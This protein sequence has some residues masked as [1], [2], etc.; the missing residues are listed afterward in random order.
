MAEYIPV[1]LLSTWPYHGTRTRTRARKVSIVGGTSQGLI[2]ILQ[3][4][5]SWSNYSSLSL[6]W[7]RAYKM[8]SLDDLESPWG[9]LMSVD[10]SE[11]GEA[12][13]IPIVGDK[14]TIGRGK[15]TLKVIFRKF[16]ESRE[17]TLD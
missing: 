4:N 12:E 14:F 9:Q 3:A 15:G 1:I 2:P 5:F 16:S 11:D 17:S 13:V 6:C 7:L 8:T 10:Q